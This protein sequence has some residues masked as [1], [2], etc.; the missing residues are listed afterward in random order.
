[1]PSA[2]CRSAIAPHPRRLVEHLSPPVIAGRLDG[3]HPQ[4]RLRE[5]P[6]SVLLCRREHEIGAVP[7]LGLRPVREIPTFA[8]LIFEKHRPGVDRRPSAHRTGAGSGHE[9]RRHAP[10]T[11]AFDG[12]IVDVLHHE[13]RQDLRDPEGPL[14][15]EITHLTGLTDDD[16]C[17]RRIDVEVANAHIARADLIIAHNARFDRP[18]LERALPMLRT[19]HWACSVRAV[20]WTGH[21]MPSAALRCP[22]CSYRAFTRE[23]QILIEVWRRHYNTARPHSA[24]GYRP[25]APETVVPPSRA[26]DSATLRRLPGLAA[27]PARH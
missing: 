18:F 21:G 25:P 9:A 6:A 19:R 10:F 13:A 8:Q 14:G 17:G 5:H 22:A 11:Y 3:Q 12:R 2:I 4:A 7:F 24:L 27:V 1:M 20:P 23:A 26:S 15:A 16:L